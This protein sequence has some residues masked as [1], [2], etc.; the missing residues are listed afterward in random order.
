MTRREGDQHA[1]RAGPAGIGLFAFGGTAA[2]MARAWRRAADEAPRAAPGAGVFS[3][4]G[5]CSPMWNYAVAA[6]APGGAD[7]ADA[8]ETGFRRS[9]GMWRPNGDRSSQAGVPRADLRTR[10]LDLDRSW[11]PVVRRIAAGTPVGWIDRHFGRHIP[12]ERRKRGLQRVGRVSHPAQE[13]PRQ[14]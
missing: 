5:C 11:R 9:S 6:S 10:A 12:L 7:H 2:C 13:R 1:A 14:R 4:L 8:L 3:A